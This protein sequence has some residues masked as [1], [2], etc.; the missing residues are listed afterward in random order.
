MD[1]TALVGEGHIRARQHVV[2]DGLPEDFD[3]EDVSYSVFG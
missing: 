3:A 2:G 1:D